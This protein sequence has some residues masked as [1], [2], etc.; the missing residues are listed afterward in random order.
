MAGRFPILYIAEADASDAILSSG[1]L[2][3]MVEAMPQASFTVVGSPKSA[4]LFADTPR[5]TKLLVLEKESRLDWIKLWDQV[6]HTKWGLVVDMRGSTLVN[7]LKR[8]KRAVRGT[9]VPGVHYVDAAARALMLDE[10]PSPRLFTGDETET[11]AAEICVAAKATSSHVRVFE[12][13]R[14]GSSHNI[15]PTSTPVTNIY[16]SD[17]C[18]LI[19]RERNTSTIRLPLGKG[20]ITTRLT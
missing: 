11:T 5:L 19:W 10:I 20:D 7:K 8:G 6:R 3:Y 9:D 17:I 2:A 16:S 18:N 15:S 4:P 1:V 12:E 14:R 13:G